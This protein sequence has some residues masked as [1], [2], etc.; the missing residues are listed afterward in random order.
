MTIEA[1]AVSDAARPR[2]NGAVFCPVLPRP[3]AQPLLAFGGYRPEAAL[4]VILNMRPADRAEVFATR[5]DE[6]PFAVFGEIHAARALM[7]WAEIAYDR[8]ACGAP[9]AFFAVMHRT[10][11]VGSAC[12]LAT[13]LLRPMQARAIATRVRRRVIPKLAGLGLRRVDCLSAVGHREAHAFLRWC[14][15]SVE[16]LRPAIGKRGVDFVEFVWLARGAAEGRPA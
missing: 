15:A 6:D 11:G 5:V 8:D 1:H 14:G 10:P 4:H 2:A 13:P 3:E 9:L 12:M 7:L 16:S